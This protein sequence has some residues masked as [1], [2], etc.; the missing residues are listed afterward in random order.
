MA[1]KTR[2]AKLAVRTA[3]TADVEA[4]IALCGRIYAD[5]PAYTAR[6]IR[7]QITTFPEGQFVVEYENEVVGYA[8]TFI[9]TEAAALSPHSWAAITGG[10]FASN[11]SLDGD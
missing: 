6:Q 9:T 11:H 3:L 4:I 5:E 1:E 10:G 2:P 8:A 7:S